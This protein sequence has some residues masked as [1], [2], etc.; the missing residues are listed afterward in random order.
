[1]ALVTGDSLAQVASQTLDNLHVVY[2]VTKMDVL[3]PLI[4]K[5]KKE[6]IEQAK[7]IGTYEISIRPYDDCCSFLL[8]DRP[9]TH[10]NLGDIEAIERPINTEKLVRRAFSV[11][12]A[13]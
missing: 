11:A 5:D 4:G 10:G 6:I 8:A 12:K 2:A 3:H 13:L 9:E 7:E 1:V